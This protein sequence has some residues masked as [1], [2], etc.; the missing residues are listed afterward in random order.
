MKV[1]VAAV[2]QQ[3]RHKL[4]NRSLTMLQDE[5]K[6]ASFGVPA[7]QPSI[8]PAV[9]DQTWKA[10]LTKNV[11]YYLRDVVVGGCLVRFAVH[12]PAPMG[13]TP[14]VLVHH[15]PD[16]MHTFEDA[17]EACHCHYRKHFHTENLNY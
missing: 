12:I 5:M 4:A 16:S 9:V 14:L 6:K 7:W 3:R 11:P 13:C 17:A 2:Q 10:R 15:R 1:V 8:E